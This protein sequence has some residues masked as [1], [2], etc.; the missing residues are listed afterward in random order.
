VTSLRYFASRESSRTIIDAE[1]CSSLSSRSGEPKWDSVSSSPER[2]AWANSVEWA[3]AD[4]LKPST[5]K[6][7]LKDASA[8]VHTMGILLEVDYKG[9]VQGRESIL[10]LLRELRSSGPGSQYALWTKQDDALRSIGQ[11]GRLTY[12]L[13]NRDSGWSIAMFIEPVLISINS[14]CIRT[15][16]FH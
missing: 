2:P 6:S 9:V 14:Y 16:I 3:K 7:Y 10:G 4:I 12:E 5:Y 15:G 13:M 8:A 11:N 1:R